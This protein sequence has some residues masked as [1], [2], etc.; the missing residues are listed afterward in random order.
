MSDKYTVKSHLQEFHNKGAEFNKAHADHHRKMSEHHA[1]LSEAQDGEVAKLHKHMA[2][3]HTDM[4][5]LCD[6][7]A[8]HC[9]EMS[10]LIDSMTKA[11]GMNSD[12]LVPDN[13]RGIITHFPGVTAVP[14]AGQRAIPEQTEVPPEFEKL[15]AIET[16]DE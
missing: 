3:A 14:R 5:E 11:A 13:V 9:E 8:A 15:L 10:S 6:E 16:G 4:A 2:K 12:A 7:H 1:G